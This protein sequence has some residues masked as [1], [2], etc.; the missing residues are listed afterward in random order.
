MGIIIKAAAAAADFFVD[1]IFVVALL[2]K[3]GNAKYQVEPTTE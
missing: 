3:I 1:V 2:I